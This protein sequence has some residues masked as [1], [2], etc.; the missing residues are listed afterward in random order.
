[1]SFNFGLTV[2]DMYARARSAVSARRELAGSLSLT[3]GTSVFIQV[4]TV[5]S[6]V[7]LARALGPQGR[8]DLAIAMLWPAL[9]SG[10]G[11][12]GIAD[13]LTFRS[14]LEPPGPSAA[15]S[16]ALLLATL[17]SI[18][19]AGVGW[20]VIQ[21]ALHNSPVIASDAQFYLWFIPLNLLTLYP[22]AVLQGR[23]MMRSFNLARASVN[24]A[25]TGSLAVLWATK[26]IDVRTALAA[27]LFANA[28]TLT[29]CAR[30]VVRR[31]LLTRSIGVAGLRQLITL[32]LRLHL[33]NVAF[34]LASRI[35][36]VALSFL[37]P[38]R[39]LGEYVVATAVGSL[40]LVIP[41][42]ASLVL[43]PLFSRRAKEQ[44]G[45]AFA[46]F[47]LL[48]LVI[49][50]AAIPVVI[51]ISPFVITWFFGSTFANAT[52]TAQ[53]LGL[54]ALVRGM[55]VMTSAVLRG[56]GS[57]VRASGGDVAGLIVIAICIVP[58]IRIAQGQGAAVAVLLGTLIAV[59]WMIYHGM[60]VVRLTP[61]DLLRAWGEDLG[62]RPAYHDGTT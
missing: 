53:L 1:M 10:V 34:L 50:V 8:G 46:K 11:M 12:L 15:F 42:A 6:G 52:A 38:S 22:A 62:L 35:D 36:I 13:A 47:I 59:G 54:A 20:L 39:V 49:T 27:S 17:Q 9:V 33:G 40:P 48:A 31:R 5:A 55:S 18:L 45:R 30:L 51:L 58:G 29:L 37:V 25:Y 43:Y 19:L 28:F 32:G 26:H 2:G 7:I 21:I 14:A 61:R 60:R 41:S 4:V 3:V 24:V 44:A 56:L 23:M 57:P 16:N